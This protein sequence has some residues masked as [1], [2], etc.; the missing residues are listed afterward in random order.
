MIAAIVV[1][2]ARPE[3]AEALV[4]EFYRR[5]GYEDQDVRFAKN[6]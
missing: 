4:P 6:L 2:D 5:R 3:D 1:R